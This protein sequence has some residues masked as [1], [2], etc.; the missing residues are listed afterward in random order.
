MDYQIGR[1]GRI[2]AARLY[3]GEDIIE[4]IEALARKEGI[5]AAAVLVTGGLRKGH[6][7]VG[8]RRE[9]PIVPDGRDVEGPGEIL[10]AGTL[11]PDEAG[12]K[13]HLHVG[14]G[15]GDRP[16]VGCL[17]GGVSSTFLILE[18]T[19]IELDGIQGRRV[20]DREQAVKLLTL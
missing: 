20:L 6:L 7:V 17:R 12:P 11:Y 3:E 15:R 2:A 9:G 8:P 13:L 14:M 19:I 10:G 18:V 1:P 16:V 5:Q 4:S